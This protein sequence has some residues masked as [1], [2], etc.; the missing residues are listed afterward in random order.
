M[1]VT[2]T[3]PVVT[4]DSVQEL[5]EH[6]VTVKTVVDCS[7]EVDTVPVGVSVA[8]AVETGVVSVNGQ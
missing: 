8:G 5:S 1:S 7:V 3:T 6:E 4:S 2:T